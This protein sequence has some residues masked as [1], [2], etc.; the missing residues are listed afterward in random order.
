MSAQAKLVSTGETAF[1][2]HSEKQSATMRAAGRIKWFDRTRGFGFMVPDEGADAPTADVLV[3][4]SVLAEHDC[5]ELPEMAHIECEVV[6]GSKGLQASRV[7]SIDTS[8]CDNLPVDA[9]PMRRKI[10]RDVA[11]ASAPIHAEVKWF[12]RI[13]GYG[14]VVAGDEPGD[15]FIHMETVRDAQMNDLLPGQSVIVR[16]RKS[17]RGLLAVAI[18]PAADD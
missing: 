9:A 13:K 6:E 3:H 5:R 18:E 14:F 16:V 4:W 15:I 2:D 7:I 11:D 8:D 1:A 12:N 17:E 10:L